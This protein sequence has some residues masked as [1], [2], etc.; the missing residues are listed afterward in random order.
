M[1]AVIPPG[2][3]RRLSARQQFRHTVIQTLDLDRRLCA[4]AAD[5]ES[6]IRAALEVVG[7]GSYADVFALGPLV[8]VKRVRRSRPE[9]VLDTSQLPG[10]LQQLYLTF[11]TEY[12]QPHLTV[13]EFTAILAG[14][15]GI[16]PYI[17]RISICPRSQS[18][19]LVMERWTWTLKQD[20]AAAS[21]AT[22]DLPVL[23]WFTFPLRVWRDITLKVLQLAPFGIIHDDLHDGNIVVRRDA[24]SGHPELALIDFGCASIQ[25]S[26]AM[27]SGRQPLIETAAIFTQLFASWAT[28]GWFDIPLSDNVI[29]KFAVDQFSATV[30]PIAY[31][32]PDVYS[33]QRLFSDWWWESARDIIACAR[34]RSGSDRIAAAQQPGV[35]VQ[36]RKAEEEA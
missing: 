23:P 5:A 8:A 29:I 21:C 17:Y 14:T 12:R 13:E 32:S 4:R 34:E 25:T 24:V 31:D 28:Q 9:H 26:R 18:H 3:R 27:P 33:V 16:G 10:D 19:L 30:T 15:Y 11:L 36:K 20:I 7:S 6:K 1:A 35:T 2:T 22:D